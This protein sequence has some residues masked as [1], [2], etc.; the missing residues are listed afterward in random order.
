MERKGDGS[1]T[2]FQGEQIPILSCDLRFVT[3]LPKGHIITWQ[4][5]SST[6]Q[7][8]CLRFCCRPTQRLED[9]GSTSTSFILEAQTREHLPQV[10]LS[11]LAVGS[12]C[13]SLFL[14]VRCCLVTICVSNEQGLHAVRLHP[15]I[16]SSKLVLLLSRIL[17]SHASALRILLE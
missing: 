8:D 17:K 9:E 10:R 13:G 5:T 12:P 6:S 2:E 1:C 11:L 7:Q 16:C 15:G 4:K 3:P 14:I